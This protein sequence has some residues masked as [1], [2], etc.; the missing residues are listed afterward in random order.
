MNLCPLFTLWPYLTVFFTV[1]GVC[2]VI[3]VHINS[4]II[5]SF[6]FLVCHWP[7]H[8]ESLALGF[9]S[10]LASMHPFYFFVLLFLSLSIVKLR[11]STP[12]KVYDDNDDDDDSQSEEGNVRVV[13][14]IW[15]PLWGRSVPPVAV[16][17]AAVIRRSVGGIGQCRSAAIGRSYTTTTRQSHDVTRLSR[18]PQLRYLLAA[19]S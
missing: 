14:N 6:G 1:I 17:S 7:W 16:N 4:V 10:L 5:V 12:N 3:T 11:F 19:E 9:H 2:Q 15:I 8:L 18:T 13:E